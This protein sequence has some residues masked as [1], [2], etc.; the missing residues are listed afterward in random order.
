MPSPKTK[1]QQKYLI[2]LLSKF[3]E[4]FNGTLG[5]FKIYLVDLLLKENSKPMCLR[6]YPVLKLHEELFKKEVGHFF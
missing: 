5:T 1:Y 2:N 3:E 4:S 6:P